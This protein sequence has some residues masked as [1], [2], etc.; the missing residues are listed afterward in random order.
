MGVQTMNKQSEIKATQNKTKSPKYELSEQELDTASGGFSWGAS[1]PT[2]T[3]VK[4]PPNPVDFSS[5]KGVD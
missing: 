3:G 4:S 2:T 1:N 5:S